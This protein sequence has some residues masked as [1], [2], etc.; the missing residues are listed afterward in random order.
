MVVRARFPD[1]PDF[2]VDAQCDIP[3]LPA[4]QLAT[5]VIEVVKIE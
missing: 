3:D 4:D 1:E 5:V 2:P